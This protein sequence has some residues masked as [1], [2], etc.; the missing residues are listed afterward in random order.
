[1]AH[2]RFE[3]GWV[4]AAPIE[5]AFEL[6]ASPDEYSSWWPSIKH[7]RLI[8][9][10]GDDGVGAGAGYSIRSPLMYSLDLEATIIEI[11]RPKLINMLARGDLVG[12]G[13]FDLMQDGLNSVITYRWYVSTT[14]KW[15]N[16]VAPLGKPLFVW[17]YHSVMREGCAGL[18]QAIGGRLV[19]TSSKLVDA[20]PIAGSEAG[21]LT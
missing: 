19:S 20:S 2:Y 6:L 11:E 9:P 5:A 12:T 4:L 15:M 17:A 18:A 13:T 14:K 1:L 7:S 10:G 8:A 21:S 16:A 3:S